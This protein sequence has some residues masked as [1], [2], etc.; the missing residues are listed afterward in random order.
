MNPIR[1]LHKIILYGG[2]TFYNFFLSTNVFIA[3]VFVD[4]VK[5][6]KH[7]FYNRERYTKFISSYEIKRR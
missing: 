3:C 2:Y 5:E 1:I 4:Y 7:S 6:K